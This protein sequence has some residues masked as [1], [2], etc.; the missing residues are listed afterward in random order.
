MSVAFHVDLDLLAESVEEMA[1]CGRSLDDVL[2]ELAERVSM[3]QATWTGDAA[4]AQDRAQEAWES[5]YHAM[6]DGLETMRA[7]GEA[8]A[9]SYDD[10]VATNLRMWGQVR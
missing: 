6:R 7:A 8:A 1:R 3:L 5:G 2:A 4:L 10:A 9:V